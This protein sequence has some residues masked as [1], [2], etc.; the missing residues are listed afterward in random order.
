MQLTRFTHACVQLDV[1]G[2]RL[3]IDPGEFGTHPDLASVDAVL[4][5]HDHFDH[6]DHAALRAAHAAAPSLVIVGPQA[7]ADATDVPVTV[8]DGGDRFDVNGV[9][10]EVVGHVQ[11]VADLDDPTIPNVGYLVADKVFHPGDALPQIEVDVLLLAMEAPWASTLDRQKALRRHPTK[12]IVPIHDAILNDLGVG[13]AMHTLR[14]LA[15]DVGAEAIE[16][17]DGESVDL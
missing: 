3:V 11:A 7:L 6:V 10:V 9:A 8:V 1:D 4:I 15:D 12:R 2:T 17:R 14:R 5:T 13:F 16:L